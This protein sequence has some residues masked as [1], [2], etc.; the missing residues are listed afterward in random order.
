MEEIK[1]SLVNLDIMSHVKDSLI[2]V[3][4][5]DGKEKFRVKMLEYI[6][7]TADNDDDEF[8]FNSIVTVRFLNPETDAIAYTDKYK[9]IWLNAPDGGGVGESV[10]IWDFIYDHECLHQLWDTF[11]VEDQIK[12]NGIEYNHYILN[13]ASDCVINDYLVRIR[14][15][16][17]FKNGVFP[18]YLEQQ[19]GVIYDTKKD[20][21]Y[22][23]YLKLLEK[24]KELEKDQKLQ[25]ACKEF[26]GKITPKSVNKQPGGPPPPPPPSI[27]HSKD[28]IKGWTDA[29]QDTL[30]KKIDP[31]KDSPKKTG[32]KEYDQG[33]S[34]AIDNIKEGLENGVNISKGGGGGGN[35][36]SDLPDIPWDIDNKDQDQQSG[37]GKS[38]PSDKDD[39]SDSD[40]S[41]SSDSDSSPSDKAQKAANE[42]KEAAKKA[43]EAADKAKQDANGSDSGDDDSDKNGS[44]GSSKEDKQQKAADAQKAADEA[45]EAAKEAQ[46]AADEAKE[47]ENNGD[48][49]EAENAAKKAQDAADKAKQAAKKAGSDSDSNSGKND[50]EAGEAKKGGTGS[51]GTYLE[52]EADLEKICKEQEE[53]I[54]NFRNRISGPLGN[55][56]KQCTLSASLKKSGLITD[57][58]FKGASMHWNQEMNKTIKAFLKKKVFQKQREFKRTYQRVKR[59]SGFVEF[60]KPLERGKKLKNDKLLINV[61]FYIDRSG[62]MQ[63]RIDNAFDALYVVAESLKKQFGHEKVVDDVQFKIYAFEYDIREINFGKRCTTGGGTMPFQQLLRDISDR[64]KDYLINVILTDAGFSDIN[65]SEVDKFINDIDGCILFITNEPSSIMKNIAKKHNT[66]LFYIE[67][68]KN[69]TVK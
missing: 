62:S 13:I 56:I 59:G 2:H 17:P 39:D 69:F 8:F 58:T 16:T 21:Q 9:L 55:F 24:A 64:T 40:S 52:S 20:T 35:S 30:D 4:K 49:N 12:K 68:D 66:K 36:G 60:G 67:A 41:D 29:I 38:K 42:A 54:K 33:Y 19:Y 57:G 22:T 51:G 34:D 31:L 37:N 15:K 7:D 18:E 53:N 43:Q 23:L 27:K 44:S 26:D 47:A 63:D 46:K 28:Y 6:N 45:K 1:S 32:N 25:D 3:S 11:G 48:E 10:R 50:D 65:V 14:K 5:Q 61:A